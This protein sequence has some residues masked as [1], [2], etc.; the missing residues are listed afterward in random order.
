MKPNDLPLHGVG[1]ALQRKDDERF[2]QG[3][4]LYVADI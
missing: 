1:A 3:R 2:L 4:G